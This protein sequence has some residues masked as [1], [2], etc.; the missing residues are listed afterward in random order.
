MIHMQKDDA[1]H[2]IV[3]SIQNTRRDTWRGNGYEKGWF[4]LTRNQ[5]NGKRRAWKTWREKNERLYSCVLL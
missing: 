5:L 2:R 4:G 1:V 3:S